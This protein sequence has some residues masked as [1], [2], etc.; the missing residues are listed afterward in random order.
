M[1]LANALQQPFAVEQADDEWFDVND[2]IDNEIE[3]SAEG[4]EQDVL[5]EYA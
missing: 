5:L 3:L 1:V 4:G 2:P